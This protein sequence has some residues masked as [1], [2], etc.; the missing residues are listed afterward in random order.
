MHQPQQA[1]S[2]AWPSKVLVA[3]TTQWVCLLKA[4][5]SR[6]DSP[7]L[8]AQRDSAR[9]ISFERKAALAEQAEA[10]KRQMKESQLSSFR[11]EAKAR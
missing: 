3:V 9:Y 5:S 6:G 4:T 7:P 2:G 10:L 1:P 11:T 8:Q